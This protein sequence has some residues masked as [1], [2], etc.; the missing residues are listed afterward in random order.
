MPKASYMETYIKE[1][2]KKN[3]IID[4]EIIYGVFKRCE[5]CNRLFHPQGIF[6]HKMYCPMNPNR[7]KNYG[8]KRNWCCR[9]CNLLFMHNKERNLHE[10]RCAEN[11][12]VIIINSRISNRDKLE[13]VKREFPDIYNL[14][15]PEQIKRF[16]NSKSN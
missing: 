15:Q 4:Y 1:K 9:Y 7:K 3:E 8:T 6:K 11:S 13:L 14:L 10:T 2:A 12:Q 16:L 5:F